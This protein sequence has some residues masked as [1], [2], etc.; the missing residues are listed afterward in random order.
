MFSDEIE[1]RVTRITF[2]NPSNNYTIAK[3]RTSNDKQ[4][5]I[6][7]NLPA[8]N[9]GESLKVK[10]YWK[11]HEKFGEQFMIESFEFFNPDTLEEIEEYLA[12]GNFEG[13]RK[14]LAK[15]IVKKFGENTL[16]ILDHDITRLNEVS[17]ISKDK[18]EIIKNSWNDQ[19]EFRKAIIFLQNLGLNSNLAVKIFS[20]YKRDTETIINSNPYRLLEDFPGF[21][22]NLADQLAG[23]LGFT[24]VS[25]QRLE[26]GIIYTL[27]RLSDEGHTFYPSHL[28]TSECMRFLSTDYDTLDNAL[29]DLKAQGLISEESSIDELTGEYSSA[30]FLSEF[31]YAEISIRNKL[32]TLLDSDNG[33][34]DS[35]LK[36]LSVYLENDDQIILAEAQ[37][38]AIKAAFKN[39]VVV[40]TGGPGT[41]KTTIIK[42]ILFL[43]QRMKKKAV[44][45]AP[46]GRAAKRMSEAT[47]YEAKTIHR[48]LEYVPTDRIFSKGED[49]PLDADFVIVDECSMIDTLLLKNLLDAIPHGASLVMV[50]DSNQ[51]PSVGAGNVLKDIIDSETVP[52]IAL[53]EIFRQSKESMI[54]LN[55]H[56]INSGNLPLLSNNEYL[57]FQF[58]QLTNSEDVLGKIIELCCSELPDNFGFNPLSDIQVLSPMHKGVTGVTNLNVELQKALNGSDQEIKF[59]DKTFKIGDKVMQ[60]RNNYQKEIFNGDIGQVYLIDNKKKTLTA[61]FDGRLVNYDY[62]ELDELMLAYAISVHKSQGSEY[63]VIIMPI[64]KEHFRLLQRNLLYTGITR[65]R[66]MVILIGT[67]EMLSYSI[68]NNRAVKRYTYLKERLMGL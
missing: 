20:L 64:I 11:T 21:T 53:T 41:G 36:D 55:A 10:G 43:A 29:C 1:G 30:V 24:S 5:T 56:R 44:L 38:E 37:K 4:I 12:S 18:I 67:A 57:D 59:A 17:R 52:V 27:R 66:K 49:D 9:E 61:N 25:R 60:N 32:R 50:G 63:P 13:I 40:I 33:F 31:F 14:S 54:V 28:F 26:A 35:V 22:F 8:L 48:L 23:Q 58:L 39:K 45:A 47:N 6:V 34:S 62:P 15:K 65:S 51:L 68:R 42:S 46:T 7:G 19:R 3:I 2:F 16:D